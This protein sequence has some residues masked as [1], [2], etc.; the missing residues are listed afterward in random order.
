V[1]ALNYR[2][3]PAAQ[4]PAYPEDVAAGI[5]WM[6]QHAAEY[7]G[8]PERL[9]LIGHSAGAH[10]VALV[11]TDATYLAKHELTLRDLSA[12]VPLDTEA[13]DLPALAARFGGRLPDTW[14][15][16]FGQD[17]EVWK[18]ASPALHVAPG[19]GIPPML[20]VYSGGMMDPQRRYNP[21]RAEDAQAFAD[22]LRGAGVRAEVVGDPKKSHVQII[23]EF[24][25][26]EDTIAPVVF[27]FLRS[28]PSAAP[29]SPPATVGFV[30]DDVRMGAAEVSYTDPETLHT[31]GRMVFLDAGLSVWVAALDPQTGLFRSASG[32]DQLVD[33][34]ISKWSRYSNGPEW[35]LDKDGPALFYVKDDAQGRGQLW[36]A[37]PPWDKAQLTPLTHDA[38]AHNWICEASL[39]PVLASTRVAIYHGNPGEQGNADVW[40]DEKEPEKLHPFARPM[41]MARWGTNTSSITFAP[42]PRPGQTE[43]SQVTLVDTDTDQS[44]VIT[45]D[46]GNKID[47]WLWHAPEFG[48]EVLLCANVDHLAVGLYRDTKRDGSPWERIATL[49]LPA[50]APHQHLKSVEPL[51]GGYGAFGR[52]YFTV[53]AGDDKDPDTSVWLFGYEPGGRH[54]I[55]RLD[56][57]AV[58]GKAAR[59]LD[60]ESFVGANEV[61]VYY[62]LSGEGPAQ[63]RRCRTGITEGQR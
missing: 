29:T 39:N 40:L 32:C 46:A 20:V 28:C 1:A 50:D 18:A 51:A 54:V 2:L 6:R 43:P 30:P 12:V 36:R 19:K 41:V 44:R 62:T 10:L 49:A 34:G 11:A 37:E 16:P 14:G 13:Y 45:A 35:G 55:R 58:T 42:K 24:G 47:P 15:T 3:A 59:R 48:G 52:S 17:A 31:E 4:F 9:V 63:L 60:P 8:D 26:P 57:G 21:S 33:K 22:T 53:Q 23:G 61:F 5:A 7:G 38:E 56:D 25:L 27:A